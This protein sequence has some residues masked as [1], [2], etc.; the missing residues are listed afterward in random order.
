MEKFIVEN[1]DSSN[2]NLCKEVFGGERDYD[3][4]FRSC[5]R[6]TKY[7]IWIYEIVNMLTNNNNNK[8]IL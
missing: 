5:E 4:N 6:N 1:V 8:I 7:N 3:E 2:K